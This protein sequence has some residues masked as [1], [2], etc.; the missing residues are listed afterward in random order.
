MPPIVSEPAS[1]QSI[2][3]SNYDFKPLNAHNNHPATVLTKW[4]ITV[5]TAAGGA[6]ILKTQTTYAPLPMPV[7][8]TVT[9]LP[10]DNNYYYC[11]IQYM[12]SDG[13]EWLGPS[14]RFQSRR[15]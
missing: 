5:T 7:N 6:G 14:N 13:S 2:P 3:G 8:C 9:N 12:K 11:Q 15:S 4:K 10:A 1:N